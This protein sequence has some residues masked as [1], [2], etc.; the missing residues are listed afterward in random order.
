M[1]KQHHLVDADRKH[2]FL[3]SAAVRGE[4][5]PSNKIDVQSDGF[6]VRRAGAVQHK[7]DMVHIRLCASN[8]N[9]HR[10]SIQN[11]PETQVQEQPD[12]RV[13]LYLV[14]DGRDE[15][16]HFNPPGGEH[17]SAILVRLR[18]LGAT[19]ILRVHSF[20]K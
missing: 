18:V 2:L 9:L 8:S 13:S 15:S 6:D 17:H 5:G 12:R 20:S 7:V 16:G 11:L 14:R 3:S 19:F 10:F 4:R 1:V